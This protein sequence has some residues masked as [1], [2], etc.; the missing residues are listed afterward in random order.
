MTQTRTLFASLLLACA[1]GLAAAPAGA[2]TGAPDAMVKTTVDDVLGI[3]KQSKDKRS[4]RALAEEKVLHKFDFKE[5]TRSAVGP[6]WAKASPAQQAALE[7]GFRTILVNTYTSALSVPGAA[8]A[9]VEIKP[10]LGK[11]GDSDAT[12]KTVVRQSGKAPLPI[13]YRLS[14]ESG[15]WLVND[16]VVSGMSLITTYRGTFS[17]AINRS[18]VDGLLK[19]LDDKNRSIA[20]S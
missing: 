18:G 13:D 20:G 16:V 19:M 5:M 3:I 6:A 4:L 1:F 8:D 12:V 2:V 15:D 10:V 7:A 17:E 14:S 11:A 9:T